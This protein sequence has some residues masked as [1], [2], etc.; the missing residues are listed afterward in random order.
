MFIDRKTGISDIKE[1][2]NIIVSVTFGL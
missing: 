2:E 1:L